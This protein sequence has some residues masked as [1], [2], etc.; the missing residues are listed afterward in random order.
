[1]KT[2][3]DVVAG[4]RELLESRAGQRQVARV[5]GYLDALNQTAEKLPN[6]RAVIR[7]RDGSA[8]FATVGNLVAKRPVLDVRI[9]GHL[10]GEV[11]LNGKGARMF[12]AARRY[13]EHLP[14]GAFEWGKPQVRAFLESFAPVQTP[15]ITEALVQAQLFR[16]M[17]VRTGNEKCRHLMRHQPV[18]MLGLP[19]QFPMPIS[20]SGARPEVAKDDA[21]GHADVIARF[22]SGHR[23]RVFEIKKPQG[24]ARFAVRQAVAYAAALQWLLEHHRAT[25]LRALEFGGNPKKLPIDAWAFVESSSVNEA[26][27]GA[28]E[29]NRANQHHA[30]AVMPYRVSGTTLDV[31][32]KIEP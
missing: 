10:V 14:E 18:L 17:A 16:A 8:F 32:D 28:R 19:F 5:V 11:R 22:G 13:K 20:A 24:K 27:R 1:M 30:L 31:L 2:T 7:E 4:V 29:L 26:L 25:M 12:H 21:L 6:A 3:D 23:L 15:K 9:Q